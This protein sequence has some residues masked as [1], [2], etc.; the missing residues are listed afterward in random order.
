MLSGIYFSARY[1][2][3]TNLISRPGSARPVTQPAH[4]DCLEFR[5]HFKKS[6]VPDLTSDAV[7]YQAISSNSG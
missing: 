6:G 1:G 2:F 7:I 4:R 3:L 5:Y